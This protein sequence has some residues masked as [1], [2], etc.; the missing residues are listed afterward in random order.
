MF[1]IQLNAY[2]MQVLFRAAAVCA[3][4]NKKK[5]AI[6]NSGLVTESISSSA[7]LLLMCLFICSCGYKLLTKKNWLWA[8]SINIT[9]DLNRAATNKSFHYGSVCQLLS[10]LFVLSVK[11]NQIVKN[12]YYYLQKF[13]CCFQ[14]SCFLQPAVQRRLVVLMHDKEKA[15][16]HFISHFSQLKCWT[17][18]MF[19]ILVLKNNKAKQLLIN[20][21]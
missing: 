20:F 19:G 3:R 7:L 16:S 14:L 13:K 5:Q 15:T 6:W 10:R 17:H 1:T 9:L 11:C 2:C 18:P 4:S 21:T 12:A 8:F